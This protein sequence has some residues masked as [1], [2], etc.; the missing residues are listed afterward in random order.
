MHIRFH[1]PANIAW[2]LSIRPLEVVI[3]AL[4]N[5]AT[6]DW[7]W[8]FTQPDRVSMSKSRAA[9]YFERVIN[10]F[11]QD[12]TFKYFPCTQETERDGGGSGQG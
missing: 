10:L 11:H 6:G 4:D 1:P 2:K 3:L 12:P 9:E 8:G 7:P 5:D